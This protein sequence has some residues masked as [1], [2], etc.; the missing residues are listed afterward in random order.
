MFLRVFNLQFQRYNCAKFPSNRFRDVRD[1]LQNKG[2]FFL[3][4]SRC[5]TMRAQNAGK[6]SY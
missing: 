3:T 2:V 1:I 4:Q 6:C 5:V